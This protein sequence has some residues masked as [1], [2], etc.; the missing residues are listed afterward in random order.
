[1]KKL[2]A[3]TLAL[4]LSGCTTF[5][6]GMAVRA[7]RVAEAGSMAWDEQVDQA[8]DV[9]RE[10]DLPTPRRRAECVQTI[11]EA[12]DKVVDPAVRTVVALLRTYWISAAAGASPKELRKHLA[13]IKDAAKDL[14]PEFFAGLQK[15]L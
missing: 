12:N 4:G 6:N 5:Y 8:I 1:M 10:K 11:H 9:C 14:P 13:G 3:C 15:L 7:E 2:L